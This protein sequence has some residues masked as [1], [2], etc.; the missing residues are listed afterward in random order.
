VEALDC[1][2]IFT[3]EK[4]N[5]VSNYRGIAILST[6]G[7]FFELLL[8]RHMYEDLK[9]QLVDCQ[10]GF[11]KSRSTVSN[12]LEYPSFVLKSIEDGCQVNSIYTV[13]SKAFYTVRHRL[14]LNKMST[15]VEPSRSQWLGF[16]LF[17]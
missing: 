15:D 2:F 6:V 12:L 3:S 9:G 11:V 13:F 7:K 10:Y 4:R 14:L 16:L 1:Y 5:D 8:C 17:W